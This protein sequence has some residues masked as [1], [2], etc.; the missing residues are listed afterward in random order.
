MSA[1]EDAALA[2][3]AAIEAAE[4]LLGEDPAPWVSAMI[5]EEDAREAFLAAA[6]AH[7]AVKL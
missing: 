4:A 5:A 6:K 1:L 3:A 7:P 2:Y